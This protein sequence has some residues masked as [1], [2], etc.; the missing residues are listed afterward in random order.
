MDTTRFRNIGMAVEQTLRATAPRLN[1]Q[2]CRD[3]LRER[4]GN[5]LRESDF[6]LYWGRWMLQFIGD[7]LKD[8]AAVLCHS[9]DLMDGV[10]HWSPYHAESAEFLKIVLS[11]TKAIRRG[12]P[13]YEL[14]LHLHYDRFGLTHDDIVERL[15]G[16]HAKP[17]GSD[18]DATE[19]GEQ[20][21]D[22]GSLLIT[23]TT[24]ERLSGRLDVPLHSLLVRVCAQSGDELCGL[25][26][27]LIAQLRTMYQSV[28]TDAWGAQE[29]VDFIGD[30]D[31]TRVNSVYLFR[32]Y[33][34][35][36]VVRFLS[37]PPFWLK[38]RTEE[39]RLCDQPKEHHIVIISHST[40]TPST[41]KRALAA[42]NDSRHFCSRLLQWRFRVIH[43]KKTATEPALLFFRWKSRGEA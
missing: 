19:S 3:R 31:P 8:G 39:M 38:C 2:S 27:H 42:K 21:L 43:V 12:R 9:N 23:V 10:S 32:E 37:T 1:W 29:L 40:L 18:G 14:T 4:F 30:F 5:E 25:L 11:S 22:S 24:Q 28:E 36:F 20:Q 7:D 34:D 35:G 17:L 16:R 41:G 33:D 15:L 6:R 26:C 13:G